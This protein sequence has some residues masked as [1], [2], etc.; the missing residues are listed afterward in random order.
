[1]EYEEKQLTH[2]NY[3]AKLESEVKVYTRANT[4]LA[5]LLN[6]NAKK[7]RKL[8]EKVLILESLNE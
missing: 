6:D 7:K 2:L 5:G 4:L 3:I 1:M 8:N